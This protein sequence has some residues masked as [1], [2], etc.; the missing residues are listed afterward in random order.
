[1]A[2]EE[3]KQEPHATVLFFFLVTTVS[4]ASGLLLPDPFGGRQARHE[5][6][7][8]EA[9]RERISLRCAGRGDGEAAAAQ[10]SYLLRLGGRCADL[11]V[12]VFHVETW[13]P[14]APC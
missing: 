10:G 9:G 2:Q 4:E 5:G 12:C 13:I 1:M 3:G 8:L 6:P 7:R 14:E 11:S